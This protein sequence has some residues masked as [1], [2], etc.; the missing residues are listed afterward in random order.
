MPTKKRRLQLS[1]DDDLDCALARLSKLVGR[2]QAT[3]VHEML[4]ESLPVFIQT[5]DALELARQGKLN[6]DGLN[7][8]VN[9]KI[10]EATELQ[11]ELTD[12]N[13]DQ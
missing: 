12:K 1:L 4:R 5:A 6:L 3:I 9:A 11:L 10:H 7:A 13:K 2:P 8:V